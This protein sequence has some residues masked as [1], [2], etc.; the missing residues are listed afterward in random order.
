MLARAPLLWSA[1]ALR[2][3]GVFC[4]PPCLCLRIR[5]LLRGGAEQLSLLDL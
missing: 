2:A 5:K 1:D 4:S 3:G